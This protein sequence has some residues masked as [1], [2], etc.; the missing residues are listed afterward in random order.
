MVERGTVL[1]SGAKRLYQVRPADGVDTLDKG[2]RTERMCGS[3]DL[4][5][6]LHCKTVAPQACLDN[7]TAKARYW[8]L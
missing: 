1:L 2:E 4:L 3:I 8:N 5:T 7:T 6:V